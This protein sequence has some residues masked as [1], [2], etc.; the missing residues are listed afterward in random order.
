MN[1]ASI[2]FTF[3]ITLIFFQSCRN[4]NTYIRPDS[5]ISECIFKVGSYFIYSDTTD[6][7]IDS[8]YVYQYTYKVNGVVLT[9]TDA[10]Y[11]YGDVFSMSQISFH[12]G[13]FYDKIYSGNASEPPYLFVGDSLGY[14]YYSYPSEA[15]T[16]IPSSDTAVFS[17]F[18]VGG[19]VYPTV[20]KNNFQLRI[21]ENTDTVPIDLYFAQNYGIFKRVEHR[22]SGDV[23][24]D[25]IRYHIVH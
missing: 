18:S 9:Y 3:F 14:E 23:S 16:F 6:H 13:I 12:N 8:E 24:W 11:T 22:P 5:R 2:I 7:I 19:S 1:K 4:C 21:K 20:Y 10:C 25:L 17:N 15:P